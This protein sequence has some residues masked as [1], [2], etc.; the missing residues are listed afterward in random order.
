MVTT[1]DHTRK[2]TTAGY[3]S[4]K[5]QYEKQQGGSCFLKDAINLALDALNFLK[6]HLTTHHVIY[7]HVEEHQ[8]AEN[9]MEDILRLLNQILPY[10]N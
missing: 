4:S 2:T 8:K 6:K 7:N 9:D 10:T 1:K 3:T 5:L